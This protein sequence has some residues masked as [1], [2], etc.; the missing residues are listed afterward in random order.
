MNI[1]EFLK[2]D[3]GTKKEFEIKLEQEKIKRALKTV[4]NVLVL[5]SLAFR[6]N[7]LWISYKIFYTPNN[8]E[9]R[10]IQNILFHII[11]IMLM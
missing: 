9:S 8:I 3:S 10:W 4:E 5:C 7:I 6:K 2:T 11:H 1:E